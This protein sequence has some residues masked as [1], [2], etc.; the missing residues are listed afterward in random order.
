MAKK[1]STNDWKSNTPKIKVLYAEF[2]VFDFHT[3]IHSWYIAFG[4]IESWSYRFHLGDNVEM[5]DQSYYGIF[6]RPEFAFYHLKI[7]WFVY[8]DRQPPCSDVPSALL[9]ELHTQRCLSISSCSRSG[10]VFWVAEEMIRLLVP[11]EVSMPI[12]AGN[13]NMEGQQGSRG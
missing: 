11:A 3:T 13:H 6:L 5:R 8:A 2:R 7:D 9:E 1:L 12:E 10:E 4:I